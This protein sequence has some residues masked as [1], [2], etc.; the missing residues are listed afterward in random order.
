MIYDKLSRITDYLG[1]NQ[2]LDIA[3]Q[4]ISSH[5]LS[6]LPFG[7]TEVSGRDVYINIMEASTAPIEQLGF[8]LHKNYMDIQIDLSGTEIIQIGNASAMS[9]I[10]YNAETDFAAVQSDPLCSCNMGPGNFII[11]MAGEPHKP[12][13]AAG[14]NESLKKCV[15]KIHL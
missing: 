8:E 7:K 10:N 13:I 1:L 11:C 14:E 2:N 9:I 5:N 15:F 12:G 4:Y 6:L 3:I